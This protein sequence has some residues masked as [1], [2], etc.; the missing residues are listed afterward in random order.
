MLRGMKAGFALLAG[1]VV[2]LV[3][4]FGFR[5]DAAAPPSRANEPQN[6]A[7]AGARAEVAQAPAA[8]RA[9][10]NAPDAPAAV[11]EQVETD[12]VPP[13]ARPD[14]AVL[15]GRCV[16]EAGAPLAGVTV[17][18]HGWTGNSQRL[19]AYKREHGAVVW[20]DPEDQ[21]T[22][23]DGRFVVR[24]VPPPP[25]QFLLRLDHDATV[26]SRGR[27]SRIEAGTVKQLGDIV[28]MR[29]AQVGGR[30]VD[31]DGRPVADV[32]VSLV[33]FD[34]APGWR[35]DVHADTQC[36]ARTGPDGSFRM[37]EAMAVAT[38]NLRLEGAR[39]AEPREEVRVEAPATHL[40]LVTARAA[41]IPTIRGVVVDQAGAPVQG[42]FVAPVGWR[43]LGPMTPSKAD[44]SFV[45]ESHGEQQPGGPV[46][47]RCQCSGYELGKTN[48]KYEW[49]RTDVRLV[50]Q[51][52]IDV[53]VVVRRADDGAAVEEFGIRLMPKPGLSMGTSS[54]DNRI[55]GG[56]H[57]EHGRAVVQ[58]VLRGAWLLFVEPKPHSGLVMHGPIEVAV[59]DGTQSRFEVRL[60]TEVAQPVRVVRGDGSVVSGCR[61]ELIAPSPGCSVGTGTKAAR[62]EESVL[63]QG[64]V[65]TLVD[66]ATTGEDGTCTVAAASGTAYA[67]RVNVGQTRLVRPDVRPGH[68]VLEFVVPDGC[69]VR[70]TLRPLELLE[71]LRERAM[72]PPSG[73]VDVRDRRKLPGIALHRRVG[74]KLES[75]PRGRNECVV[76][77]DQGR[78]ELVG[79]PAGRWDLVLVSS[80]DYGSGY[81][82]GSEPLRVGIVLTDGETK[83]LALDLPDMR[84]GR[85]IGTFSVDG[86][87]FAG[88]LQL[89]GDCGVLPDGKPRIA[90][91]E[92]QCDAHGNFEVLVSPG[93]WSVAAR[94]R[95]DEGGVTANADQT[96][97][98]RP[99][100]KVRAD[101]AVQIAKMRIRVLSP[102]GEP[103][104]G[105]RPWFVRDGEVLQ[106]QPVF[107]DDEGRATVVVTP[108]QM[109]L[110]T[111]VRSLLDE[112][113]RRAFQREHAGSP[114]ALE[115]AQVTTAP[116]VVTAGTEQP[117]IE[118]RLPAEWD[119]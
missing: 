106:I 29:G 36:K 53:E 89:H 64:D 40:D 74:D 6:Q 112:E 63:R 107:T 69:S 2:V 83:D 66:E 57:H 81:S 58:G 25:Y 104:A 76:F 20:Q 59:A 114:R 79:V 102:S 75:I 12:F 7:P 50:L 46:A 47:L 41:D 1:I 31:T 27:W 21:R 95:V 35:G 13:I 116:F 109:A 100:Q 44:G 119:R 73:A 56:W 105:L 49:G 37:R 71:E 115:R 54:L 68:G 51:R 99:G 30:V 8:G 77:D 45:V 43:G 84:M 24:F 16:D 92:A 10:G 117:E 97:H 4:W 78:A 9:P 86:Q 80:T 52:G 65:A 23:A 93:T 62:L 111:L 88:R 5:S 70:V 98:V 61:V 96:V 113:G 28:M 15:F 55:R 14:E 67:V 82:T 3:W 11:R 110:T 33:C 17:G 32:E 38:W 118:I 22:S 39:L 103:V 90:F 34:L 72:L 85:I 101:L 60:E 48:E 26:S 91:A 19:A 18:L 108:G 42:A 94:V 87:P